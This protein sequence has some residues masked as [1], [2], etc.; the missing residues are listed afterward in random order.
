MEINSVEINIQYP[1]HIKPGEDRFIKNG[2]EIGPFNGKL[3]IEIRCRDILVT[4]I[5]PGKHNYI[6]IKGA[7]EKQILSLHYHAS[8]NLIIPLKKEFGV[9]VSK[10][11]VSKLKTTILA[12]LLLVF[13]L[14]SLVI[15]FKT[16]FLTV[17]VSFGDIFAINFPVFLILSILFTAQRL[18]LVFKQILEYKIFVDVHQSSHGILDIIYVDNNPVHSVDNM[19]FI[20]KLK[21]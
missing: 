12:G 21:N 19:S 3:G 4:S 16:S 8:S 13:I 10:N 11:I 7:N 17:G 20:V 5:M 14:P 18:S 2:L 9:F 15:A 6:E 1:S